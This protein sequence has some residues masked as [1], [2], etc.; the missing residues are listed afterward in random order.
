MSPRRQSRCKHIVERPNIKKY[1]Q[2]TVLV[3]DRFRGGS[4][5]FFL[6]RLWVCGGFQNNIC[7]NKYNLKC[8]QFFIPQVLGLNPPWTYFRPKL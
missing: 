4:G 7:F 3:S 6:E 1:Y 8:V 5:I 2:E